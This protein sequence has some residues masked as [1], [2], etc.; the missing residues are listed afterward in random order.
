MDDNSLNENEMHDIFASNFSLNQSD[1]IECSR[2]YESWHI[3][4]KED[5]FLSPFLQPPKIIGF[6]LKN[7]KDANQ[8]SENLSKDT[9]NITKP[10]LPKKRINS[11]TKKEERYEF[12]KNNLD[13]LLRRIKKLAFNS[14][15]KYDNKVISEL[16][17]NRLGHGIN[18]KK[19]LKNNHF[20]IKCTGTVFNLELL[21]KTQG[22]ILSEDITTKFTNFPHDHNKTLINNL[23]NEVDKIKREK[24][25]NLFNKT[26]S[27]CI[28]HLIGKKKSKDLEGLEKIFD[29]EIKKINK[30]KEYIEKLKNIFNDYKRIYNEKIPRKIK[31]KKNSSM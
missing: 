19:L 22:E 23:L 20:Q 11:K 15:L 24:F 30:N 8:I 9:S 7:K 3:L 1:N 16:Y 29:S 5:I 17:N 2:N 12:D 18:I 26:L 14:I 31:P 4:E 25:R 21:K 13:N 10:L 28:D 27:E 6:D